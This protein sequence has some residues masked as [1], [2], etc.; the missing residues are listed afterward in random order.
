MITIK[1]STNVQFLRSGAFFSCPEGEKTAVG[2]GNT[3]AGSSMA[4]FNAAGTSLANIKVENAKG[5]SISSMEE[6]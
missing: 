5:I 4:S 6:L 2:L 3:R 1:E